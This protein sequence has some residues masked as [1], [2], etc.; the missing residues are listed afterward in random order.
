VSIIQVGQ[1]GNQDWSLGTETEA[2]ITEEYS[3]LACLLEAFSGP[4]TQGGT[5][6]S[7]LDSV[8]SIIKQEY[9]LQA[10]L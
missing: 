9:M 8:T 5:T 2:Q 3:L 4:S 6:Y 1:A 7:E 10:C